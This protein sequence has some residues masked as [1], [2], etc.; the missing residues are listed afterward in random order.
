MAIAILCSEMIPIKGV[1]TAPPMMDITI[2]EPASFVFSPRPFIPSAKMVGNI[3][4]M[5][6]LVN[7]MA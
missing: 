6:K 3:S 4:D 1:N 7:K 5:K 2:N